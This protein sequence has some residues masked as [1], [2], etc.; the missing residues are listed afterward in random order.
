MESAESDRRRDQWLALAQFGLQLMASE[1]PTLGGAVGEAGAQAL[2]SLRGS[3][4]DY[5]RTMME[6]YGTREQLAMSR[7]RAAGG[8]GGGGAPRAMP[9][10]ALGAL[11]RQLSDLNARL[12]GART[13]A[14]RTDIDAA[15]RRVQAQRDLVNRAFFAQYGLDVSGDFGADDDDDYVSQAARRN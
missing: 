7:A 6:L 2:E 14:E 4:Q 9:V 5:N 11:D 1:R 8:G 15:I 12:A 3:Y 10:G 13:P